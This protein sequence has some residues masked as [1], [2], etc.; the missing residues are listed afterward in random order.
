MNNQI[1][2]RDYFPNYLSS[3]SVFTKMSQLG[4]PW[5]QE[6]G[7]DMDDAYFTMYSGVKNPSE[8]VLLHLNPDSSTVAN[9]LTIA[10]IL[11]GIYSESWNKLWEAYKTKYKPIDNYN[12]EEVVTKVKSDNRT[13]DKETT[14][15]DSSETTST[16]QYGQTVGT[17]ANT[18]SFNFGFNSIERSPT[19][20]QD[21]TNN[22]TNGGSDTS[23]GTATGNTST[24]DNTTDVLN[25]TEDTT[26][27]RSGNVGQN[28]YQE[29]L[30]QEFELWRWNFFTQVFKD[31]DRFLTLSVYTPC[32]H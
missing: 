2:L 8:F 4:A 18:K 6:V 23:T 11:Y 21:T 10:R 5:P 19:G 16:T 25:G 7:Q 17:V 3:D 9:S 24:S 22:E 14:T 1:H 27:M 28:S 29:L 31:V 15:E 12:I 26:L 20:E 30:K 13:I 32:S